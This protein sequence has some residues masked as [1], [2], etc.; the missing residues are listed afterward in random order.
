MPESS[1]RLDR[2]EAMIAEFAINDRRLQE[3]QEALHHHQ[4]TLH[5]GQQEFRQRQDAFQTSME[6]LRRRQEAFQVSLEAQKERQ[7]A[8]A[9]S[10][11][12]LKSLHDDN[13]RRIGQLMDTMNRLGNI[14]ISHDQR[15]DDLENR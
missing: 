2:I 15:L 4:E 6:A 9:Q 11:E 8:L 1:D 7:E 5:E 14:V 13:E 10:L 12:L 3:R